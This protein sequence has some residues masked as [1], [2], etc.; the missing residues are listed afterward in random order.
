MK[1]RKIVAGLAAMSMMATFS[2]QAVFAAGVSI[3][4]GTA[5]AEAGGSAVVAISMEGVTAPVNAVEFEV[6]YDP[7][8]LTVKGVTAGDAVPK[9]T[10]GAE[11]FEGVNS[12][13]VTT[14]TVG[15][16]VITYATGLS[17]DQYC[18]TADGVIANVEFA[19]AEGAA[20]GKY[21]VGIVAVDRDTFEGSG[22]KNTEIS[23]AYIKA[24]GTVDVYTA[25]GAA[26]YV[27]VGG[28]PVSVGVCGDVDNDGDVDIIDVLV[29]NQYLLS[30]VDKPA[31]LANADVDNNGKVEDADA[32]NI[33]KSLVA[34]VT[35]PIA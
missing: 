25:T 8:V 24:D 35:L 17:D 14:D 23:T 30:L 21:E 33:L 19:V 28:A 11:N 10:D 32:I 6:T 4:A 1:V 16:I 31:G 22:E 29:L 26:G 18:F 34:L 2:A 9:G 7:A 27:E 13:D 20:A 15:T 5:T 12:F 3:K